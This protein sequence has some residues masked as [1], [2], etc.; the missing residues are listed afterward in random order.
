[1]NSDRRDFVPSRAYKAGDSDV[2]ERSAGGDIGC[3]YGFFVSVS[4]G[5]D[6]GLL[7]AENFTDRFCL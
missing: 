5:G 4:F 1:M 2:L 6:G 3:S 7:K